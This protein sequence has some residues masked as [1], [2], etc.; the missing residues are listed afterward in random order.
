[1]VTHWTALVKTQ[2]CVICGAYVSRR[3]ECPRVRDFVFAHVC[4]CDV[5]MHVHVR[6][7]VRDVCEYVRLCA[8]VFVCVNV[9]ARVWVRACVHACVRVC[10][11]VRA[12]VRAC[13]CVHTFECSCV[14]VFA[15][16]CVFCICVHA[17]A[18]LCVCMCVPA[19][20]CFCVHG[21]VQERDFVLLSEHQTSTQACTVQPGEWH[22]ILIQVVL[23]FAEVS[24]A[25]ITIFTN[26][27]V[28]AFSV[29]THS[30][31]VTV[32]HSSA[33]VNIWNT[34]QTEMTQCFDV[35]LYETYS[36]PYSRRTVWPPSQRKLCLS[37]S[38]SNK[39]PA[40]VVIRDP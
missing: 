19:Y 35:D 32:V 21:C 13:V 29:F 28:A 30:V 36:R 8:H 26:A 10:V 38:R 4:A 18:Y 2:L 40:L 12:C 34:Q 7:R 17:C 31:R 11:Y 27:C 39:L 3:N 15:S 23:T 20:V 24:V 1:M 33:F 37:G 16:V 6:V 5:R 25:H 9:C 22:H 14:W